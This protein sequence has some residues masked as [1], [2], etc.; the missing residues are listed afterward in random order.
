MPKRF[1]K[2]INQAEQLIQRD[3]TQL[4]PAI[5]KVLQRYCA[6]WYVRLFTGGF[7][8]RYVRQVRAMLVKFSDTH[9]LVTNVEML[10]PRAK[11]P[12]STIVGFAKKAIAPKI[13]L[14][15]VPVF[16]IDTSQ[17]HTFTP[18]LISFINAAPLVD[19]TQTQTDITE[20]NTASEDSQASSFVDPSP[21]TPSAAGSQATP[22]TAV[23][24]SD[25]VQNCKA[26]ELAQQRKDQEPE[27][28]AEQ[29]VKVQRALLD[30]QE[31][32]EQKYTQFEDA[33]VSNANNLKALVE[34]HERRQSLITI[35]AAIQKTIVATF[36]I[37]ELVEKLK[38]LDA[39]KAQAIKNE[40]L[41][42]KSKMKQW[43]NNHPATAKN[44]ADHAQKIIEASL[45]TQQLLQKAQSLYDNFEQDL[46]KEVN[47]MVNQLG[48]A[49]PQVML[50]MKSPWI[51]DKTQEQAD[52][53]IENCQQTLNQGPRF[54]R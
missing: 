28:F 36:G 54:N 31:A 30:Q 25:S 4:D 20:H 22:L 6:P 15:N 41:T 17:I 51:F 27:H 24:L 48:T 38:P 34:D 21:R 5:R 19:L 33:R 29:R 37:F 1:H 40:D 16:Q 42:L 18:E 43:E 52:H 10:S 13:Q 35:R 12:L 23:T 44:A 39:E 7:F 45:Q 11:N 9:E 32:R 47:N 14:V 2:Q 53:F 3:P 46:R 26:Q 49:A 50:H 8:N